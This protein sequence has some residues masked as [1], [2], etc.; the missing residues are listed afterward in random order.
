MGRE[1]GPGQGSRLEV[2][3]Q[4]IHSP[5]NRVLEL[6]LEV[7]RKI[8][9]FSYLIALNNPHSFT[10][11]RAVLILTLEAESQHLLGP[12]HTPARHGVLD[13]TL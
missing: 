8:E 11:I 3:R 9:K 4:Q 13:T 12:C 1:L 5:G 7:V 10:W 6:V 2:G